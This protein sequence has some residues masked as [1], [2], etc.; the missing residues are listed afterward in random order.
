MVRSALATGQSLMGKLV[1]AGGVAL[2]ATAMAS[3]ANATAAAAAATSDNFRIPAEEVEANKTALGVADPEFRALHGG[4]GQL[5][6]APKKIEISIPSIN[7][8]DVMRFSSHFGYRTDPFQ[9]RRKNHKGL[10]ISG[11]IGTPIYATADGTIGRAQWVSG[12]GKYVEVEHG[13]AIQ[14]RYGHMSALNVI[15]GQRV[16]QGDIIG[17]MGSTGRSTGSHL[18]YEVRIAG[19][20]VNP[21]SFLAPMP[22][23]QPVANPSNMLIAAK[24]AAS[25]AKGGPTE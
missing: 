10:D 8:V 18:H 21:V 22:T 19:E 20:P 14:T 24:D 16:K 12:Y 7:P 1:F 5:G 3:P 9:G 25:E 4:W 23:V 17:F 15:S 6:D 13:N 2:M 11:P